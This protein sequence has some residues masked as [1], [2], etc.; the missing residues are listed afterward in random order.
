M[1]PSGCWRGTALPAAQGGGAGTGLVGEGEVPEGAPRPCHPL[2]A[3][4]GE[5]ERGRGRNLLSPPLCGVKGKSEF[6][7]PSQHP[8]PRDLNTGFK[9]RIK[10]NEDM[11]R[12]FLF[13]SS[14]EEINVTLIM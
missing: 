11:D 1:C 13:I 5:R 4:D 8:D 2:A 10:N 12:W 9:R 3:S 7:P 14:A 6:P